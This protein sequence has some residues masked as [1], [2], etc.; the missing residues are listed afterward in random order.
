M[1]D[2]DL[3][4]LVVEELAFDPCIDTANIAIAALDGVVT[5][6][7]TVRSLT[8][9]WQAISDVKALRGVVGIAD[10]I[11][12]DLPAEH[13]RSDTDIAHA[14]AMRLESNVMVPSDVK[15]VVKSGRVTLSGDASWNFQRDEA[16]REAYGVTGVLA[17]TN[18]MTLKPAPM[19]AEEDV[20]RRIH[21]VFA[22]TAD[23]DANQVLVSVDRSTVTLRG[24]VR[25]WLEHDKAT[26]AA[27][28]MRGVTRVD[29]RL[30]IGL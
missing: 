15:F 1:N 28:S 26:Q 22:R 10:E 13:L 24:K 18:E 27:W 30:E 23:T 8:E 17:V 2:I 29:N 19:P 4:E 5:L 6:R 25:T 20:R 12:V 9:K 3:Q 7:G 21:S 11:V 14:L 16:E